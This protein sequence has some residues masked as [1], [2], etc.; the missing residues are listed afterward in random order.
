MARGAD[1]TAAFPARP[2]QFDS[3]RYFLSDFELQYADGTVA[4]VADELEITRADGTETTVTDD[5]VTAEPR[6]FGATPLGTLN[7][8]GTLTGV[9]F[10]LGLPEA[11][12]TADLEDFPTGSA[13]DL[14][15]TAFNYRS[16]DGF[17][18]L[19]LRLV[20]PPAAA[21]MLDVAVL[22]PLPVALAFDPP[23]V[24]EPGFDLALT[25]AVDYAAW[26]APLDVVT[27]TET[28]VRQAI[29]NGAANS[30]TVLTVEH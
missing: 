19:R 15:A 1:A 10:L 13:L 17:L 18:P 20:A 2:F 7:A 29:Q 12:R 30:F 24:L 4:R 27:A 16:A 9:R 11:V 5:F 14:P 22:E 26:L 21:D 6:R 25:L 28:Q 23:F 3:V 8:P